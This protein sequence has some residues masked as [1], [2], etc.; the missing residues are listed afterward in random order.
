MKTKR[1][2][3]WKWK[4]YSPGPTLKWEALSQGANRVRGP[5]T[6]KMTVKCFSQKEASHCLCLSPG[7]LHHWTSTNMGQQWPCKL[8]ALNDCCH[9]RVYALLIFLPSQRFLFL[10]LFL[11]ICSFFLCCMRGCKFGQT[12]SGLNYSFVS[13]FSLK[14]DRQIW[15]TEKNLFK[16]LVSSYKC[17]LHLHLHRHPHGHDDLVSDPL[18]RLTIRADKLT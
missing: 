7:K 15:L 9:F 16:L 5:N 4:A 18:I 10:S 14:L 2:T 17:A 6:Q 1:F 13:W 8:L 12:L 3:L 11:S